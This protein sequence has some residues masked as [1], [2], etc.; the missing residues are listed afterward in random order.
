MVGKGEKHPVHHLPADDS[1][2]EADVL[3]TTE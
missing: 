3:K 2:T 1:R